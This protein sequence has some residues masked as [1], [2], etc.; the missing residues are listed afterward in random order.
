MARPKA[1]LKA[2]TAVTLRAQP[3]ELPSY[4]IAAVN[5]RPD[6]APN[7]VAVAVKA[8]GKK[9]EA[10]PAALCVVIDRIIR[11][12]IVA[13]PEATVAI[14]KAAASTSPE[15]RRCIVSAA[16][17]TVPTAKDAIVRAATARALPLAFLTFSATGNSGFSF[18]AATLNPANISDL[19]DNAVNSPEQPP[20]P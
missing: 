11:A 13:N 6:L 20:S 2:F 18:T 15:L 14:V 19:G 8:A 7:V 5:L 16:I 10:K 9:L 3:R 4:V 17:S 1:F 12:A